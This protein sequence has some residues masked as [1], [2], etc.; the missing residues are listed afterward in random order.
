MAPVRLRS[1]PVVA[2][3]LCERAP[4]FPAGELVA[5]RLAGRP[6]NWRSAP[7]GCRR[8]GARRPASW[9]RMSGR[10]PGIY[11]QVMQSPA[12]LTGAEGIGRLLTCFRIA[13]M[14]LSVPLRLH[15]SAFARTLRASHA[16]ELGRRVGA[17][18]IAHQCMRSKHFG[19]WGTHR[20]LNA[21]AGMESTPG[22]R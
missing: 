19:T 14:K 9:L 4:V 6:A 8:T 17:P 20:R 10:R 11:S 15:M 2:P 21:G 7:E 12:F 18:V 3:W 1:R 5:L 22:A 13:S 16:H